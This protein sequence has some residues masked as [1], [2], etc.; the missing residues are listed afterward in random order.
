ME[1]NVVGFMFPL[2]P[3]PPKSA[4]QVNYLHVAFDQAQPRF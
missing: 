4:W 2:H 1:R 3:T